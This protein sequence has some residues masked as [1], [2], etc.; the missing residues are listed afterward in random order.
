MKTVRLIRNRPGVSIAPDGTRYSL[1]SQNEIDQQFAEIARRAEGKKVVVVQGLGFVG[2]AVAASIASATDR[3]GRPLYFVVGIDQASSDSFWKIGKVNDGLVPGGS[4][5]IEFDRILEQAVKERNNLCATASEEAYGIAETIVVDVPLDVVNTTVELRSEIDINLREFETAIRA[6]ARKMRRD[7]L[8]LVE[9]TVPIGFCER[10]VLPLL[11]EERARRGI[12]QPVLLAHAAER[13]TPGKN[14]VSSIRRFWR[15]FAGYDAASACRTREFLA[16]FIDAESYP[17]YELHDMA[18]SE[19]GKVLENSYRAMNIAFI[20]EWT[21]LAERANINLWTVIDGIRVR[22]GTHD[23]MRYPGFGVGGYCLTKDSLLA[24]WSATHLFKT[25]T[26]LELTL[27]ALRINRKMPLHT[28]TLLSELLPDGLSDK[29]ILI[30]GVTYLPDV[31][32]TRNSPTEILLEELENAGATVLVHDP[33]IRS[34]AERPFMVVQRDLVSALEE[35]DL[36]VFAVP[37]RD[38]EAL[39]AEFLRR[40]LLIVDSNNV[41][42]DIKAE[43]FHAAGCRILGVGKGHWRARG[44]H[45]AT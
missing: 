21:L 30:C 22:K 23:N 19:M 45:L 6:F 14:Y 38:Y 4:A 16:S 7:A 35:A 39:Q 32:D 12:Q 33:A 25:D 1:P 13:V 10:R 42:T 37:H 8:I 15:S 43:E 5:D 3:Q 29:T 28:L 18:S 17:L 40:P 44:Y 24:Q 20:H 9:T 36:V 11:K 26:V 31:P 41:L 27:Q 2:S 34:W